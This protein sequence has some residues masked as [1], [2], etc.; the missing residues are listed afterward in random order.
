MNENSPEKE[1]NEFVSKVEE[2]AP[3]E[4]VYFEPTPGFGQ[5]AKFFPEEAKT[6]PAKANLNLINF[7]ILE[8]TKPGDV[9]LDPMAGTYST[10]VLAVL[11]GRHGIGVEL[12]EKFYKLGLEAKKIVESS[13]TVVSKGKMVVL[14]G[15]ARKLSEILKQVGFDAIITSPPYANTEFYYGKKSP[16][17]WQ[18]LAEKTGRKA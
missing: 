12:E 1:E 15:D 7:L 13:P 4:E 11:N 18:K 16:E 14:Q 2:L 10:C 17:F 6:H 5:W 9:I 3:T 8:Y